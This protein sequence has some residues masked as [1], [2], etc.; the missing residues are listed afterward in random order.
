VRNKDGLDVPALVQHAARAKGV[1][2]FPGAEAFPADEILTEPVDVLIPAALGDVLTAKNA[3]RVQAKVILEGA[4]HP[5]DI[6]ADAILQKKGVVMVPD[7]YANAGGVT[8]S[9]FEWVQNIQQFRWDE[10]RVN[11]ELRKVMRQA[12]ADLKRVRAEHNCDWRTAA[13]VLAVDRVA[14]A[15]ALR[16]VWE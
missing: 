11:A 1:A 16:G 13:F 9:Y 8:V 7:I 6:E 3:D 12:Y 15:S 4:N 10:E 14:T 5:T 2:K